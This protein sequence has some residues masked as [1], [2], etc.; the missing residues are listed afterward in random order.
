M[1]PGL[2]GLGE[3]S[4]LGPSAVVCSVPLDGESEADGGLVYVYALWG[5][6][7][8]AFGATAGEAEVL[9]VVGGVVTE[10]PARESPAGATDDALARCTGPSEPAAAAVVESLA[11]AGATPTAAAPA[12]AGTGWVLG[13]VGDDGVGDGTSVD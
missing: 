5:R 2:L 7:V 1:P 4:A 10:R 3:I 6:G 8:T 9:G 13:P 12:A 11:S